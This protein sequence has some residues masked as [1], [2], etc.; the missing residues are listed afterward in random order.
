MKRQFAIN[1]PFKSDQFNQTALWFL[2]RL[3]TSDL[4][5]ACTLNGICTKKPIIY[6]NCAQINSN[7][8]IFRLEL[9]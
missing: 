7:I 2:E 6:I 5:R 8:P 4:I 1:S 3:D 9:F